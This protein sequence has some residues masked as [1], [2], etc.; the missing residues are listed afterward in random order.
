MCDPELISERTITR[1]KGPDVVVSTVN[2]R[3]LDFGYLE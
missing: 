3:Y 2:S 1:L